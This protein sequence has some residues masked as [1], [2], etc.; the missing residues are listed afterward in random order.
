MRG[1]KLA[2]DPLSSMLFSS[3]LGAETVIELPRRLRPGPPV[4]PK[5]QGVRQRLAVGM[6]PGGRGNTWLVRIARMHH[7]L[8]GVL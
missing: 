2:T 3:G 1:F 7:A 8:V 6:L 4:L 5:R